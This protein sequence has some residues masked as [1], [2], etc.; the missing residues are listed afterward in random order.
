M[1]FLLDSRLVCPYCGGSA[2]FM[3]SLSDTNQRTCADKFRYY[4]CYEC[5]LLFIE[6][7]PKELG[8]IYLH[9]QYDIPRDKTG[10]QPRAASQQWKVDI[11][12]SLV[13]PCSLF[14]VGPATGE[15]AFVARQAGFAPKLAE[16]D[17][18]CCQFLRELGLEVVQ[19]SDPVRCLASENEY[20]AICI[21]QAIEHIPE[22]WKLMEIAA[23]RLVAGGVIVVSTPNPVSFQAKLLGRFWPHLDVPR[24]LYLIPPKWF[25]S[26][27][28]KHGLSVILETTRDV[29]SLGLNYY[30]WYLAVRNL[31]GGLL[32]D[33]HV[34]TVARKITDRFRRFEEVE[35]KGCC[36][37]IAFQKV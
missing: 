35:G 1:G 25:R 7:I 37:T 2:K 24:H 11:L 16:M 14:E 36:Y 26:F 15:F 17:G 34:Q 22:F 8:K 28:C 9:E 23:E 5:S 30:G 10:F 21:W 27:A 13:E 3:F 18:P 6:Q 4:R 32:T 29:G 12:K 20:K 33:R 19:T 31:S